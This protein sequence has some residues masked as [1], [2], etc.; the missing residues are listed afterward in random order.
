M[1]KDNG[2]REEAIKN[3]FVEYLR[4]T[5]GLN[6]ATKAQEVPT[7]NGRKNFDYLLECN[8]R[9]LALEITTRNDEEES[10]AHNSQTIMVWNQLCSLVRV[11][12]LQG[13]TW[14]ETPGSYS[15]S[16]TR[17]K[18]ILKKHGREIASIIEETSSNLGVGEKNAVQTKLGLFVVGRV[19]GS[20]GLLS[21]STFRGWDEYKLA[22]SEYQENLA[23]LNKVIG[24]KSEQLD[25][26]ADRRVLLIS[27][28]APFG[29]DL[30]RD[31][32]SE[33]FGQ[34]RDDMQ[35]IDEVFIEFSENDFTRVF[36]HAL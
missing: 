7:R 25:T 10:L 11:D 18:N 19:E 13:C 9:T 31:A 36:P 2:K 6:W 34:A 32:I 26:D 12:M 30:F 35:N 17:L 1:T 33:C 15:M 24:R 22:E 8:E 21:M 3:R 5:E 29:K 4:R 23:A 27:D 16:S 28:N 14:F 20:P